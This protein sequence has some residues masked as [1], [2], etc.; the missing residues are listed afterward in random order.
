LTTVRSTSACASQRETE[1]D[2]ASSAP[3]A[4]SAVRSSRSSSEF[5]PATG[6]QRHQHPQ[7]AAQALERVLGAGRVTG[8]REDGRVVGGRVERGEQRRHHPRVEL[9]AG[10]ALELRARLGDRERLAVGPLGDERV[11]GVAGQ[12]DP[13]GERDRLARQALGIAAAVPALVRVTNGGRHRVE[14]R[15]RAQDALGGGGVLVHQRPLVLVEATGLVQHAVGDGEL[16]DV[17][18][19]C[20]GL[21]VGDLP[22]IQPEPAGHGHRQALDGVA[23]LAGVAVARLERKRERADHRVIRLGDALVLGLE[24][25]ERRD[26]RLL[27]AAQPERCGGGLA[28]QVLQAA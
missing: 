18:Q 28:A 27:P 12:H 22:R 15:Q 5:V 8:H 14:A 25:L 26:Q 20:R 4:S 9:G 17:V 7:L 16:A 1:T 13:R 21:D 24:R 19:Q 11:P 10:A 2:V 6:R 23:V 3:R